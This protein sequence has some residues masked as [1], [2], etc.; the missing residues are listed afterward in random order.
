MGRG[1]WIVAEVRP[2]YGNSDECVW[3]E[4]RW[5]LECMSDECM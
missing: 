5:S 4:L 1:R 2:E 3:E